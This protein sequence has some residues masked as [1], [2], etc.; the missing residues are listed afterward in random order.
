MIFEATASQ[1]P[2]NYIYATFLE[3]GHCLTPEKLRTMQLL[4][5]LSIVSLAV[6]LLSQHTAAFLLPKRLCIKNTEYKQKFLGKLMMISPALRDFVKV[7]LSVLNDGIPV[8][9]PFDQGLCSFVVGGGR[10]FP[11]LNEM[12]E[13]SPVGELVKFSAKLAEFN[14]EMTADIPLANAPGGLR[15]GD[16]VKMSNGMSVRVAEITNDI[17]RIDANPPLA[18]K[19]LE[20]VLKVLERKPNSS[21]TQATFAGSSVDSMEITF[22]ILNMITTSAHKRCRYCIETLEIMKPIV[23]RSSSRCTSVLPYVSQN[24]PYLLLSN[25]LHALLFDIA[26]CRSVRFLTS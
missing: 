8:D 3:C 1:R 6:V 17:V 26:S 16:I 23:N 20:F 10:F 18:G 24:I 19:T 21:L 25:F 4:R 22:S 15:I 7:D 2:I 5:Q 14:P 13:K 9:T 12:A 11:E